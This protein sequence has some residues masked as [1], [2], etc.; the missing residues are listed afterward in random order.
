[1]FICLRSSL[2]NF[3]NCH[4]YL[5]RKTAQV[6][7]SLIRFLLWSLVSRRFF[8]RLRYYFSYFLPKSLL[9]YNVYF[10]YSK[11]VVF[12]LL[13]KRSMAFSFFLVLFLPLFIF[14]HGSLWIWHICNVIFHS[15][16]LDVY[17]FF[18]VRILCSFSFYA[19]IFISLIYISR[20][21]LRFSTLVS[22]EHFLITKLS[23]IIS[24]WNLK[25]KSGTSRKTPPYY[26]FFF[27]P[28]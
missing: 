22:S 23:E 4:G 21:I 2:V 16:L 3:K 13:S 20:L 10:K 24:M 1:M 8:V 9:V 19:N 28:L 27:L 5:E 18:H 26:N 6:S 15:Y 14:F 17:S 12:F 7:I 11:V 25:G